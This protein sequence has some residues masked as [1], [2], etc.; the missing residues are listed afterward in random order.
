EAVGAVDRL[1]TGGDEGDHGLLAA[2]V[3]RG[4]VHGAIAARGAALGAVATIATLA[5]SL[6]LA[7]A[8]RAAAGLV[9]EALFRVKL[10]L[11]GSEDELLAT[12]TS[13]QD[14]VGDTHQSCLSS[15]MYRRSLD[16]FT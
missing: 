6:G 16:G 7:T 2:L 12:I 1:A 3:A 14:L 11:T 9:G 8:I 13:G 15:W 10:L 4:R 5:G